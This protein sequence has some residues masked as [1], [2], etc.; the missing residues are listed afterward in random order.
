[1]TLAVVDY[2]AGNLTSVIKGL[3]AVGASVRV[4]S[5]PSETNGADALVVPGV[6]HFDVTR[7]LVGEW[8]EA[9]RARVA[10][11]MPLLG[12]C[13]GLQW[14]FEGSAEAPDVP[15]LGL[16]PGVC[17]RLPDTV[18]VPH[19]G[20]NTLERRPSRL[21]ADLPDGAMAYFTHSFA[22]PVVNGTAAVTTHGAAF[23]AAIEQG[24]VFGTQFH[25]EKSG[26]TGLKIL[27]NFMT[28]VREVRTGRA[29][30]AGRPGDR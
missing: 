24:L 27:A 2:G 14:L 26:A 9:V 6:G 10:A 22:G 29:D 16:L 12:I 13:V 8:Q 7:S 18:K 28:V 17:F 23:S 1:V 5:R 25:P 30:D 21:L 19:V 4:V 11:G 3:R 15:G 20:W